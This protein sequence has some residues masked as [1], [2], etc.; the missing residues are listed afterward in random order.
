MD[1]TFVGITVLLVA[2]KN[3]TFTRVR[4]KRVMICAKR[5]TTAI[6]L[7]WRKERSGNA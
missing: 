5:V 3:A 1:G 4:V 7:I 2:Y 6:T